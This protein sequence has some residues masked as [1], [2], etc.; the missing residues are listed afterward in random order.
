MSTAPT[1]VRPPSR[2]SWISLALAGAC[3]F[4]LGVLVVVTLG[5]SDSTTRTETQRVTAPAATG[6]TGRTVIT[7]TLVPRMVGEP[8]DVAKERAERQ[9]FAVTV[10]SGG[11][12]FGVVRDENWEVV[13][14]RPGAGELIEQGSTIHVDI[15]K[16]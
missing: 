15:V 3:G 7:K 11:G 12:V 4:L 8:L 14:Q 13:A 10:D 16:R 1:R 6:T 2:R 5:A 9:R